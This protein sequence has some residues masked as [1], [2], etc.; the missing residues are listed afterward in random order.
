MQYVGMLVVIALG[1][2]AMAAGQ[3]DD[4]PGLGGIGLLLIIG[5]LVLGVRSL[6]RR[7]RTPAD[8]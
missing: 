5:T 2:A 8:L 6:R 3:A 7:R 4:S 1:I